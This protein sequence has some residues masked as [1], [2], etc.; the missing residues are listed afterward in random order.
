MRRRS[1]ITLLGGAATMWPL[2]ARAQQVPMR[3]LG[4]LVNGLQANSEWQRWL[5]AFRHEL[6][7]LGWLE[8]SNIQTETRFSQ[9]NFD[10]LPQLAREIVG[11]N[12]DAISAT[13]TPA[14][15]ALQQA[16]RTIPVV[17][18][19]VSDPTGSG[20]VASLARPGGNITGFLYYEDSITG[21]WLGMLKEIAPN[22][23]RAAVVGNPKGFPYRHFLRAANAIGPSLGLEIVG[24]PVADAADIERSIESFARVPNS[25][26][27]VPPD[28][29][30]VENRDLLIALAAQKHLPA[31]Y[32]NRSFVTAGGLMSYGTDVLFQYRQAATYVDRIL[33]GAKPADLPVEAPTKYGT[34]LNLKTAKALG[35]NVPQTLLVRADEVIE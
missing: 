31:V 16:T 11:L 3:R 20:I 29:T 28:N 35:F 19:Q 15:K 24:T 14:V 7:G 21:K 17:F 6:E 1:F 8:G 33:R 32:D 12:P 25:G 13:T 5:D 30:V 18:V 4:V 27:L 34:V 9:S 26:L 2:A 22:L 23:M 10:G